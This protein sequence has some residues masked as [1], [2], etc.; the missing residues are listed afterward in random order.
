MLLQILIPPESSGSKCLVLGPM[1]TWAVLVS[2]LTMNCSYLWLVGLPV[3]LTKAGPFPCLELCWDRW[4]DLALPLAASLPAGIVCSSLGSGS[5]MSRDRHSLLKS[6]LKRRAEFYG[7][8][9]LAVLA[10]SCF[11]LRTQEWCRSQERERPSA[12]GQHC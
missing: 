3:L 10:C 9:F 12:S 5:R 2:A 1:V 7:V 8:G 4:T 6:G 11:C